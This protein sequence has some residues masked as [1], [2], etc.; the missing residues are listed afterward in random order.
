M[1]LGGLPPPPLSG[2]TTKLLPSI[3]AV[4][5][6]SCNIHE[7]NLICLNDLVDAG[8]HGAHGAHGALLLGH[9]GPLRI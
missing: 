4:T 3:T 2:P 9:Q 7:R 8:A 1:V 5:E 6:I